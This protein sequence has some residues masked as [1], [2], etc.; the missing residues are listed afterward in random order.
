MKTLA[1][2][3][4]AALATVALAQEPA[5]SGDGA[6]PDRK[7]MRPAGP[8]GARMQMGSPMMMDSILRMA[9]DPQFAAKLGLT[10]EQK[11]KLKEISGGR[12]HDRDSQKAVRKCMDRQA[13]LL[14]A[15][16]I[17]EAAIMATVD[18][19]C[20][21]RKVAM[22]EHLKRM[23]AARAVLTP[24]QLA[25]AKSLANEF[26]G[27]RRPPKPASDKPAAAPKTE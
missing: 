3:F 5:A 9:N 2:T 8:R 13:E 26:R 19:L 23:I 20:E 11:A 4:V 15:D 7:A 22:K 10:D 25:K 18:E 1:L 6:K 27:G 16:K 24:E 21:A 12:G 17:D 14:S